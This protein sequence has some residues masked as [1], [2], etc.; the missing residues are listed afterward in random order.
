MKHFYNPATGNLIYTLA[1]NFI[2][3]FRVYKLFSY[4]PQFHSLS[5]KPIYVYFS[6]FLQR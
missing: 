5:I 6:F 1:K 2:L 3:S 4:L